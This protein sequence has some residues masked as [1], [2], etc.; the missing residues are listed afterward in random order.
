MSTAP[1]PASIPTAVKIEKLSHFDVLARGLQVMDSTAI[2]FC[3]DN[4]LPIIVFDVMQPGNIT[5][6]LTGETIGTLV[7]PKET[8]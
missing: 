5:K 6:A 7:H 8:K 3:M 4:S 1:I 2:T